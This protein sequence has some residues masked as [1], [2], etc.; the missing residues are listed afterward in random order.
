MRSEFCDTVRGVQHLTLD[1][2]LDLAR[3]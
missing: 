1:T 2:P 3:M